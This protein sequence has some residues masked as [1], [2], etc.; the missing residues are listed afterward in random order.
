[1]H[2]PDSTSTA[3][4]PRVLGSKW[5]LYRLALSVLCPSSVFDSA[6][7]GL[8]LMYLSYQIAAWLFVSQLIYGQRL[9]EA[10]HHRRADLT[11]GLSHIADDVQITP[12]PRADSHLTTHG[13]LTLLYRHGSKGE[14]TFNGMQGGPSTSPALSFRAAGFGLSCPLELCSTCTAPQ[15]LAF[16]VNAHSSDTRPP[17]RDTN[18]QRGERDQARRRPIQHCRHHH[19]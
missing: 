4:H 14:Q 2:P 1:M 17:R 16:Q 11:Y 18:L 13:A 6:A 15:Y 5:C 10:P 9:T 3:K 7:I 19:G 8:S 12:S